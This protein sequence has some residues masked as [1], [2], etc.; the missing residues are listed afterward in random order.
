MF[1]VAKNLAREK[2]ESIVWDKIHNAKKK[3]LLFNLEVKIG[4]SLIVDLVFS[5]SSEEESTLSDLI[6]KR[7]YLLHEEE[8]QWKL[9][10]RALWLNEGDG[11][12]FSFIISQTKEESLTLSQKKR[13]KWLS[14]LLF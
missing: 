14:C 12:F 1:Q 10:S 9:K 8:A 2:K 11:I 3:E 6:K 4:E 13:F 7:K 5:L